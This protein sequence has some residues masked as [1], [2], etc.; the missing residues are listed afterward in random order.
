VSP[1]Y[2]PP[3]PVSGLEISLAPGGREIIMIGRFVSGGTVVL[4]AQFGIP[5]AALPSVIAR[6]TE[7]KAQLRTVLLPG[8]QH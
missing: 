7:L 3:E 4:A 5:G 6:L 2:A 8:D 1:P